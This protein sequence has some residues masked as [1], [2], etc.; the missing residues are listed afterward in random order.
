MKVKKDIDT[1][2]ES[3]QTDIYLVFYGH[4]PKFHLFS[5]KAHKEFL[6]LFPHKVDRSDHMKFTKG[7]VWIGALGQMYT[8]DKSKLIRSEFLK[9]I[10]LSEISER[11]P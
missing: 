4:I 6:G 11:I 1:A 5:L 2:M 3:N 10:G 8:N 7:K 9:S